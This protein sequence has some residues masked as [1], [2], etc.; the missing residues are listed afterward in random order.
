MSPYSSEDSP[1]AGL[2]TPPAILQL[3]SI[4]INTRDLPEAQNSLPD[5]SVKCL[6]V[7]VVAHLKPQPLPIL[8]IPPLPTPFFKS[9]PTS[10]HACP[11][12]IVF[13]TSPEMAIIFPEILPVVPAS[14]ASKPKPFRCRVCFADPCD[15]ITAS[16]CGHIFCYRYVPL[17][18]SA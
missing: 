14:E 5:S 13:P 16:T 11:E 15:D 8:S 9:S 12:D 2:E 3:P 4:P 18:S 1:P 17:P 7:A 6:P 10:S